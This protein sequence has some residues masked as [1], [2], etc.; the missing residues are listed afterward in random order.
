MGKRRSTTELIAYAIETNHTKDIR[1]L[2]SNGFHIDSR[3]NVFKP[4]TDPMTVLCFAVSLEAID[5]VLTLIDMGANINSPTLSGDTPIHV[6][7]RSIKPPSKDPSQHRSI[8]VMQ[9]LIRL[10]IYYGA[11][12][13]ACNCVSETPLHIAARL[14]ESSIVK[15]LIDNGVDV[16]SFCKEGFCAYDVCQNEIKKILPT[17]SKFNPIGRLLTGVVHT[18]QLNRYYIICDLLEKAQMQELRFQK[19]CITELFHMRQTHG[20]QC[21]RIE[22]M[23]FIFH[24]LR[25]HF[26]P[27]SVIT[28]HPRELFEKLICD[29]YLNPE[30]DNPRVFPMKLSSPL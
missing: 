27:P 19:A 2:I 26:L 17:N 22:D 24:E 15:V 13:S 29:G 1:K 12:V 11:D 6:A 4:N 16:T 10:L 7:I 14:G 30:P 18:V 9:V 20:I 23:R 8:D 21:D 25:Q 28:Q 3:D 5:I